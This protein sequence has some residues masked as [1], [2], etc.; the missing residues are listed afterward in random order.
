MRELHVG[1]GANA[2]ALTVFP[3]WGDATTSRGYGTDDASLVVSELPDG[4]AVGH[5]L[6][7][8]SASMPLLIT[9]GMLLEGG[10]QTRALTRSVL[11][12]ATESLAVEVVCVEQGRW[13]GGAGHRTAGRRASSRIRAAARRREDRGAQGAVWQRVAQYEAR[14][15]QSPT[16]SYADHA[17]RGAADVR[18]LVA[19]MRTLPGQ[20]GV[21]IGIGGHPVVAEVFDSP[22]SLRQQFAAI[23]EAAGM[24]ALD[25]PA[26]ATPARRAI[27]L[28]EEA[29]GLSLRP[30][31]AAGLGTTMTGS[32]ERVAVD[33][34][35]WRRRLV[36]T[37][38]TNARH[39]LNA[40]A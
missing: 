20:L 26:V 8:N 12:P 6:A 25:Q 2:G 36:H 9:E 18:R 5:V 23:M 17:D 38:V 10:W 24:D 13:S 22:L 35:A 27:R 1:R 31:A 21:V 33:A 40:G 34:L 28:I 37:T 14:F 4:P 15:G 19:G 32:S 16:S 7:Q 39:P 11:L 29:E 3:V 30:V